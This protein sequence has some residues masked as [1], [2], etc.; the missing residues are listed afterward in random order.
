MAVHTAELPDAI[1]ADNRGP[2][3]SVGSGCINNGGMARAMIGQTWMHDDSDGIR[4]RLRADLEASRS[5]FHDLVASLSP[6][7]WRR[8]STNPAWTNGQVVFHIALGFFLIVPLLVLMRFFALLPPAASK[9][10][11]RALDAATPLFNW[12]NA[13]GPR[14][15]ARILNARRIGGTFDRVHRRILS[16]V[17]KMRPEQWDR[18]MYYP[19]R[20]ES[21][22]AEFMTFEKLLRYPAVHLR[23]HETQIRRTTP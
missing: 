19:V 7:D 14:F 20:W 16:T 3:L 12:I 11:A 15:G 21:R 8:P 23:H 6:D 17:D 5:E 22:F 18:G 4:A 2:T 13:L 10:F 9:M 1:T